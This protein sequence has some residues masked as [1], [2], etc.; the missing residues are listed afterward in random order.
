MKYA[1]LLVALATMHDLRAYEVTD[2]FLD[3]LAV[4]ESNERC[5]IIADK[6]QSLG[7]FQIKRAAW[8]DACTRNGANWEYNKANAFNYPIARQVAQW[9]CEWIVERL[10]ANGIKPTP[11]TVYMCYCMGF[12]GAKKHGFNTQ[13]DYPAL[14]RARG[15]L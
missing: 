2:G 5:T 12:S 10:K 14:N 11:I 7:A 3:K 1:L 9:H 6:G 4:I 8:V 15:I 13:L